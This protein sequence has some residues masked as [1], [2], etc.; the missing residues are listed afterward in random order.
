VRGECGRRGAST[1]RGS[2]CSSHRA[3]S[4]VKRRGDRWGSYRAPGSADGAPDGATA[5][6]TRSQ[7]QRELET[8]ARTEGRGAAGDSAELLELI[9]AL[10]CCI[11]RI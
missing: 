11:Q 7:A 8:Q 3:A 6:S 10:F 4:V 2:R 5:R 1:K 9:Y